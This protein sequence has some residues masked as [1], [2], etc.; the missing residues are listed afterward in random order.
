MNRKE[1]YEILDKWLSEGFCEVQNKLKAP[2]DISPELSLR[3][4][5]VL[6]GMTQVCVEQLKGNGV[7]V[8]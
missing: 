7:I 8:K 4:H 1:V 2:G 6:K 3:Y 5:T